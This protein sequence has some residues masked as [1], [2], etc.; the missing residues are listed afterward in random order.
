MG[1]GVREG[2]GG[3]RGGDGSSEAE[4]IEDSLRQKDRRTTLV[5]TAITLVTATKHLLPC[6]VHPLRECL[7]IGI[8]HQLEDFG[9][10]ASVLADEGARGGVEDGKTS[11]DVP[12]IGI[13]AEHDVYLDS[14]DT[15]DV[16]AMFPGVGESFGPCC[17]HALW[18]NE[19]IVTATYINDSVRT[20]GMRRV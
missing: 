2:G 20:L 19:R 9:G 3:V 12:F 11:V 15:A 6:T 8:E 17:A 4:L 18:R 7:S 1:V 5:V 16:V 14:F 10:A 13:D